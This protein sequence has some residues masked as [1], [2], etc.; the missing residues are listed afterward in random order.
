MGIYEY[1]SNTMKGNIPLE[2]FEGLIS[3]AHDTLMTIVNGYVP[4]WKI[5]EISFND[6]RFN[7]AVC[8]QI[9]YLHAIGG[10]S[11]LISG[12]SEIDITSIETSGFSLKYDTKTNFNS[13]TPVNT[14]AKNELIQVL[15]LLGLVGACL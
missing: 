6:S 11:A 12:R 4:Y 10:V 5:P 7:K 3:W 13:G 9:E 14:L 2:E 1:Y 15:R 8:L